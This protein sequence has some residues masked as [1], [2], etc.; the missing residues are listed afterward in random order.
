MAPETFAAPAAHLVAFCNSNFTQTKRRFRRQVNKFGMLTSHS[1]LDEEDLP[2]DFRRR[3]Q[4]L[5]RQGVRGYGYWIWKPRIV[6]LALENL[7]EG[8]ILIYVDVG[9]HVR[10]RGR[11][12]FS[13]WVT[14]LASSTEDFLVFSSIYPEGYPLGDGRKYTPRLEFQW[15]KG[16][17]IDK[18]GLRGSRHLL[19]PQ[20]GASIFLVRNSESSRKLI[21]DWANFMETDPSLIDDS[22]S[23]APDTPGFIEHRHDQSIFSLL[24]KVA[25]SAVVRSSAEYWW[26]TRAGTG[27]DWWAL[28]ESPFLAKR[29]LKQ[30]SI[31]S[32]IRE[33]RRGVGGIW[34][35]LRSNFTL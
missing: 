7:A 25:G 18:M 6:L 8:E 28:R 32:A 26:P 31:T 3:H 24:I 21:R 4:S 11:A 23:V 16:D 30:V 10:R 13:S 19:S 17:T 2:I 35:Q 34:D 33:V 1:V 27:A 12:R 9:F 20:I 15:T 14:E 22:P 5:L 29:D